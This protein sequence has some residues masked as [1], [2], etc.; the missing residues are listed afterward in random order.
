MSKTSFLS[1]GLTGLAGEYF[2]GA[3]L[4][5]RGYV[6]S[7]TLRNTRGIG[8]LASN[9]DATKSVG[10]QVKTNQKAGKKWILNEKVEKNVATNLFFVFVRLNGHHDAPKYH[11]VPRADVVKYVSESSAPAGRPTS[12]TMNHSIFR[13]LRERILL[14]LRLDGTPQTLE[15]TEAKRWAEASKGG[16]GD[17]RPTARHH[18]VPRRRCFC[19]IVKPKSNVCA[20]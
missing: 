12:P 4:S 18:M 11:I 10:I 7:S 9:A 15:G 3:E 17:P 6:A 20:R 14:F 5:R 13:P 2:V 16:N 1:P 8:I 19:T